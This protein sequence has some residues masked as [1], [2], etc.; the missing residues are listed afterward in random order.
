[1]GVSDN[2]HVAWVT[3]PLLRG[4][5]I[6]QFEMFARLNSGHKVQNSW[7]VARQPALPWQPFCAP[8]FAEL[9]SC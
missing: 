9:S 6:H 7:P 2:V 8:L 5:H 3:S 4:E 1:V